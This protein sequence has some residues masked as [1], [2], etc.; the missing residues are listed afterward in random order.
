[1]QAANANEDA[2]FRKGQNTLLGGSYRKDA[3]GKGPLWGL[4]QNW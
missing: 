4:G 2:D 3:G 1:M